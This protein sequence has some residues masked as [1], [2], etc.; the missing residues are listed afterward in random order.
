M[1]R[2]FTGSG[3]SA[4]TVRLVTD[5]PADTPIE[6]LLDRVMDAQV[7]RIRQMRDRALFFMEDGNTVRVIDAELGPGTAMTSIQP[8]PALFRASGRMRGSTRSLWMA[9]LPTAPSL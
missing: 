9:T 3:P 6:N 5:A 7:M 1:Q 4:G 8:W 2:P